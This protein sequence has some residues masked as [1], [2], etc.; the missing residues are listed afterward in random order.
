ML[1]VQYE[2]SFDKYH[3]N[4]ERI[5]RIAQKTGNDYLEEDKYAQIQ[6]AVA[7]T[8]MR[9]YPE[10]MFATRFIENNQTLFSYGE[11]SFLEDN[12]F[13]TDPET[14]KIFSFEL[15]EGDPKTAL[16]DPY[17]LVLS[18]R[19]AKKYFGDEEPLNKVIHYAGSYEFKV[20]GVMRNI[21]E[22]S[23]FLIDFLLP[24]TFR[25]R[26]GDPD[27]NNDWNATFI[28][29][30]CL[31]SEDTKASELEAKFPALLDKYK[32]ADSQRKDSSKTRLFLQPLTKIHLYSHINA[33]I[34][35]NSNIK[36][37]YILSCIS[38]LILIIACINYLN[39]TIAR[40]AER[41]KE[42]G[43]RKV[44]GAQKRQLKRQFFGESLL[45]TILAFA[46][47]IIFVLLVLPVF[48]T[49]VERD[50]H[51]LENSRLIFY[52]IV[53]VVFISTFAGIYPA[54]LISSFK[55]VPVMKGAFKTGS[56]GSF[57]RNILVIAQFSISIMLIIC[58]LIIKDQLNYIKNMD[59]GYSKEQIVTIPIRDRSL[60]PVNR[61]ETLKSELQKHPNIVLTSVSSGLPNGFRHGN[62]VRK[63]V[64]SGEAETVSIYVGMVDYDFIDLYDFTVIEGR[65]FSRDFPSDKNGAFLLNETAVKALGWKS[66]LG[67]ELSHWGS[68]KGPVVGLV[69]DFHFHTLHRP[70]EPLY[71]TL[72]SSE[73]AWANNYLSVKIK[74]GGIPETIDFLRNQMKR[75][76]PNYPFEYQFFDDVFEKVYKSEQ[77]IGS[78]FSVFAMLTIF[79][80]CM[81][82]FGLAVFSTERRTKEIGIRKVLGASVSG[83]ILMLSKEFTKWVLAANI[84]AWPVA[85]FTMNRWLQNFAYRTDIRFWIFVFSTVI[86][87]SIALFTVSFQAIKAARSNPA[88]VLRLE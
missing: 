62:S 31:L 60:K 17:S 69:K 37:I 3:V 84:I 76:S 29:T 85:Y 52:L 33:E 5:Y 61:I 23:H 72:M 87:F 46:V 25:N 54:M 7:P 18:E 34:S 44:V 86:A 83:I 79:I 88:E 50:F 38:L 14:F 27:L 40:S 42:V 24:F 21:P 36:Y 80:A 22:N 78:I 43:I 26:S 75:F 6:G 11:K 56:K 82:L 66:F 65:S 30:Y 32:Y 47:S 73:F 39:L 41:S 58:T 49:F 63:S 10:V 55:P 15:L 1:Y 68:N 74:A 35:P 45:L 81:G 77:R 28:Y 12:I 16:N 70:I 59:V 19:M 2:L 71:L 8:V 64:K 67:R 51:L 13:Y 48:N 57:L 9:E 4:A 53:L 20:T